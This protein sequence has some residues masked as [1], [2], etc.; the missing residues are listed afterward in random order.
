MNDISGLAGAGHAVPAAQGGKSSARQ[1]DIEQLAGEFT[2]RVKHPGPEESAPPG[3]ESAAP[4]PGKD[5]LGMA[6]HK[7]I[8]SA[9]LRM[10]QNAAAEARK[11]FDG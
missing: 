10:V 6:I 2:A 8:L 7:S 9:G 1:T 11:N 4:V 5:Q 3:E